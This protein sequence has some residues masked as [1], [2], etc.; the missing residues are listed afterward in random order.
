MIANLREAELQAAALFEAIQQRGMIVAGKSEKQL[1]KEIYQLAKSEFGVRTHWHKRIVRAG[2][3]TLQPYRENPPDLILQ[4]DDIVF[5]DFGPV[6]EA[7]EA[8]FGRT[9]VIGNNPKKLKLMRD[10]ESA[11]HLGKAFYQKQPHLPAHELFQYACQLAHQFGWEFGG[12]IAG[13]IIGK[14][15]H[16]QLQPRNFGNYIHPSNK[17]SMAELDT[18]GHAKNWILE[19]HFVDREAR[20]GGFFEQ[21]LT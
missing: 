18:N 21:L 19:I 16:E 1:N 6:F 2:A 10:V 14:F 4:E 17:K 12:P 7:W 20:I 9:Y 8:D 3:N 5:F 11:W 13:H 15:P